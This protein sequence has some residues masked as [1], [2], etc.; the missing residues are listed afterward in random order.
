[1]TTTS[2]R[3]PSRLALPRSGW[4]TLTTSRS[5]R[6]VR[7]PKAGLPIVTFP[8]PHQTLGPGKLPAA[9]LS[10]LLGSLGQADDSVLVGPGVGRDAAAIEFGDRVLVVKT[11]PITFATDNAAA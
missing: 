1:R 9:L 7:R 10:R 3:L 5:E 6:P 11:D 4:S 2:R 8:D